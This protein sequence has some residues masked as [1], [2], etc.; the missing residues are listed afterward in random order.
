M[1]NSDEAVAIETQNS[2]QNDVSKT[3]ENIMIESALRAASFKQ[4]KS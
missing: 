3:A 2:R 4:R 1:L